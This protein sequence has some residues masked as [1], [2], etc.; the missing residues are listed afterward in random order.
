[1]S[2]T[3]GV[4]GVGGGEEDGRRA[5]GGRREWEE[6]KFV[7]LAEARSQAWKRRRSEVDA[8]EMRRELEEAMGQARKLLLQTT[9]ERELA[10]LVAVRAVAARDPGRGTEELARAQAAD[11][12]NMCVG[13]L[14]VQNTIRELDAEERVLD[15]VAARLVEEN[16]AMLDQVRKQA[17]EK[18]SETAAQ[19]EAQLERGAM[20]SRQALLRER[21]ALR[22]VFSALI[23]ESGV[24]WFK[25]SVYK[26]VVL[27]EGKWPPQ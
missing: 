17:E 13:L 26:D 12:D 3:G 18:K 1:M 23:L 24:D 14:Q 6:A 8:E 15:Q 22:T 19:D 16:R 7:E 11:K 21:T 27:D 20:P 9:N 10:R 2:R 25:D 4:V 5:K